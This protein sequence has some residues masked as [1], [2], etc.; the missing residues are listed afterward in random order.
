MNRINIK[1]QQ[2]RMYRTIYFK[3][4]LQS[5]ISLKVTM[6][7]TK[8]MSHFILGI[9]ACTN[10]EQTNLNSVT[11]AWIASPHRIAN[12]V[13]RDMQGIFWPPSFDAL[14]THQCGHSTMMEYW[15]KEVQTWSFILMSGATYGLGR[16]PS[17]LA[18]G[19]R[20][21]KRRGN[22]ECTQNTR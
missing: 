19:M 12:S 22:V 20:T 9:L 17:M 3:H 1:I 7:A 8:W 14:W 2:H 13:H 16:V 5:F 11:L 4:S 18:F 15:N 6:E 21:K 10:K